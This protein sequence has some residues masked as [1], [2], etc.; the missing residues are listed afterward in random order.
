MCETFLL[1][2]TDYLNVIITIIKFVKNAV[3]ASLYI[4]VSYVILFVLVGGLC[5]IL[6][7]DTLE[8]YINIM[9]S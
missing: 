4:L 2:L 7:I 1:K 9:F 5:S 6:S 8:V 3:E